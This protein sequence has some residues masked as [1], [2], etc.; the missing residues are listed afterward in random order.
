MQ[1]PRSKRLP[2]AGRCAERCRA[3]T[4]TRC[5][6]LDGVR[7]AQ[8]RGDAFV[9]SC[10]DSDRAVRALLREFPEVRDLEITGAGLEAAFLQLT[11]GDD[12]ETSTAFDSE[13][14]AVMNAVYAK[15]ELLRLVRNKR[16][17]IFSLIFPLMLFVLI[18][19]TNKD[20]TVEVGGRRPSTSPRTTWSAWPA[21]GR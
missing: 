6:R 19:G 12:S 7:D 8:L 16:T 20:Q 21:T 3:S 11:L 15:Y 1:R 13:D 2:A 5:A 17:F 14:A 9:L 18:A 4:S 10:S